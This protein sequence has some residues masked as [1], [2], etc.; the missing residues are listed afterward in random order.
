MKAYTY[1]EKGRYELL[2]KPRP[3]IIDPK[4]AVVRVI[5]DRKC[6]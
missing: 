5:L 2:D 6:L 4:E 1:I 3:Q